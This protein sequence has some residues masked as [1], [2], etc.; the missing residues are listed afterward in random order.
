[1]KVITVLNRQTIF[2]IAIQEYGS[3]E[4]IF[5]V[6]ADDKTVMNYQEITDAGGF[7]IQVPL[8]L[9]SNLTPGQ[10]IKIVSGPT[11]LTVLDY[12]TKKQYKPVT[13]YQ[14]DQTELLVDIPDFNELDF[15]PSDFN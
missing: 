5:K 2:D 6:L 14:Y 3:V 13:N 4:A 12:Y 15:N 1:M 7:V 10:K 11:N 9:M 8:G